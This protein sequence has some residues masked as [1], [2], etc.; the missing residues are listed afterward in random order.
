MKVKPSILVS[1]SLVLSLAA[2]QGANPEALTS[3]Q[4]SLTSDTR[5]AWDYS[6]S[7][8]RFRIQFD[9]S[10][11]NL[12]QLSA[13]RSR[14]VPWPSDYWP[15][16]LDSINRR[17]HG[18]DTLSPAE[19]YDQ[20]YN[21][22]TPDM[23]LEPM[24]PLAGCPDGV[25]ADGHDAY[26][27]HLGPA[28]SWQH[29]RGGNHRARSIHDEDGSFT[30]SLAGCNDFGGL[31]TW[32]GLGHAWV[33]AAILEPEPMSAVTLN[34]V[35]FS[36][37][38]LKA[39]LLSQYD[40]TKMVALGGRCHTQVVTRDRDGR[41][42]QPQCRD[43]N[44]GSFFVI[45]TNMLGMREL[46]IAFDRTYDFEVWSRPV[47][48]YRILA[49]EEIDEQTAIEKLGG[50]T[51]KSYKTQYDSSEA[52]S[53]RRV[54]M[55]V[56]YLTES[57][58][59]TEGPLV[60]RL[61]EYTHQDRYDMILELDG[62]SDIVGGQW[63]GYSPK[64]HPAYLW[65]PLSPKGGNP[66]ISYAKVKDLLERSLQGEDPLPMADVATFTFD[67]RRSI[68]DN[69]SSGVAADLEVPEDLTIGTLKVELE[70]EHPSIDDLKVVLSHNGQEVVLHSRT[71]GVANG[72]YKT[73][74]VT[75]FSG[76]QARGT[77][78]LVVTDHAGVDVG[79][80]VFFK[81][82][83]STARPG[84]G[85]RFLTYTSIEQVS[86]PDNDPNGARTT[87]NV[88]ADGKIEQ[89]KVTVDI[90]HSWVGDLWIQLEHNGKTVA[91]QS[92][93]GGSSEN[94]QKTYTVTGFTGTDLKG[95]W[96]LMV[97]DLAGQDGGR[98]VSWK[99]TAEM[100]Q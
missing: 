50:D 33:G 47:V 24:D 53:W 49:E 10:Y 75:D 87:I 26:Y 73:Y 58:A 12:R 17:Y 28:A 1:F 64:T 72:L 2:C 30:D 70:I 94:L 56:S 43:T 52:I 74:E 32:Q 51:S 78:T 93:E 19:K 37:N 13:G 88:P 91:L 86:I 79:E 99:L 89:L 36:V 59:S 20:A 48:A 61:S 63:I 62:D 40:R 9:Y 71:G 55:T 31:R 84:S 81:L 65:L 60:G 97:S 100:A 14:H 29:E 57:S 77:W 16:V 98:I 23:S 35:T 68:P 44:A 92:R 7:P 5:D 21:G 41:L 80:L 66:H 11:S 34:G 45:L 83:I 82:H 38:D 4:S 85:A 42:S 8:N 69:D 39:L 95:E 96:T 25:L 22:W 76:Q 15:T 54:K 6:N 18:S 90:A 3:F 46:P 67:T 27:D